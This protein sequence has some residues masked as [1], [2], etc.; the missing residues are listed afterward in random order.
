MKLRKKPIASAVALALMSTVIPV[1]AQQAAVQT[2]VPSSQQAGEVS[3]AASQPADLKIAQAT[4]PVTTPPSTTPTPAPGI[5]VTVTGIR[6]S[7][8][9]SLETKRNSDAVTEVITAEDIGK[10]P[11]KNIADAVQ[12]LPGVT[13]S[14]AAGGEGGFDENDRVSLRGTNPSLTQTLINGHSV[15]TG[16][17]FVLD[18]VGTVGRSVSFTLLPSELVSQ[19]IVRKSATADLVEGG[20]AGAVDIIT[21][22]PLDFSKPLTFEASLQAVY[23]D[24]PKKTDGQ[25]SA[26][27]NWKNDAGTA[28]FLIQGFSEKRHLRRDGQETLGYF[29]ISPT[30]LL[31]QAHP[32][33][34]NVQVPTLIGSTLFEQEREREGGLVDFQ[35]DQTDARSDARLQRVLLAS[36]GD[37]LQPQLDVFRQQGVQ[38]DEHRKSE[39]LHGD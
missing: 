31:A 17:W 29:S 15:A 4:P 9:K 32:D 7:L 38:S 25:F 21:R 13:I 1:R 6:Y 5:S 23:A 12:R 28:G 39:L 36:E 35:I 30:S 37:Q 22:K 8:E 2:P 19:V 34:A 11:D 16:D 20:I 10:L 26:L 27:L 18:Q 24:L 33:L 14:S 3:P